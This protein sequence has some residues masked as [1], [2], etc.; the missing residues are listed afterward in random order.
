MYSCLRKYQYDI[1]WMLSLPTEVEVDFDVVDIYANEYY[2]Q[3]QPLCIQEERDAQIMFVI[4][5]SNVITPQEF[6][7]LRDTFANTIE[8][9][10]TPS[11]KVGKVFRNEK[12]F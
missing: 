7:G 10:A 5:H 9:G 6:E 3:A 2:V 8:A 4:E 11:M 1:I 12:T